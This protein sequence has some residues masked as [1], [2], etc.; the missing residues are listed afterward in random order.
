[1]LAAGCVST[2]VENVNVG[3]TTSTAPTA[4]GST[5]PA[6][7][8]AASGANGDAKTNAT[9]TEPDVLTSDETAPAGAS[10]Y[11][12]VAPKRFYDS[13][14]SLADCAGSVPAGTVAINAPGADVVGP[15][16]SALVVN[17]AVSEAAGPGQV[18]IWSA[19]GGAV[20]PEAPVV[21]LTG[22]C[23][24]AVKLT[25][26]PIPPGGSLHVATTVA[27][28]VALDVIG[29]LRPAPHGATAGRL[30]A[31]APTRILDSGASIGAT[32]P[33]PPDAQVELT[34]AGT[35]G[36]PLGVAGA[37]VLQLAATDGKPPGIVTAWAAG[38]DPPPNALLAIP[39]AGWVAS[40]LAIVP[41]SAQGKITVRTSAEANLVADI[42][43]FITSDSAPEVTTG[44]IIPSAPTRLLD[45]RASG[46][47]G[48]LE[49]GFRRDVS[50]T[51]APDGVG[52]VLVATDA[53]NPT[54]AG[55][56]TAYAAGTPRPG[57]VTVP[58]QGAG[59]DSVS[60]ALMRLGENGSV[61]LATEVSTDLAVDR[62]A[63][64][65][66]TPVPP[67]PTVPVVAPDT[68]GTPA[69]AAFDKVIQGF[70]SSRGLTGASVAI[71]K[72]G[73]IVYARAYG[74]MDDGGTPVRV[75]TRFRFASIS[76]V[77]TAAA[78]LQLI[79]AGAL[80]LNDSVFSLLSDR[81]PFN[82]NPDPRIVKVTVR[83]LLRHTSGF[84]KSTDPFF[85]E[86]PQ[87]RRVFGPSG[88]KTCLDAAKWFVTLPL[89]SDPGSQFAYVNMNYCLLSLLVEK[90]TNEAYDTV[91]Q[92][93]VLERRNVRDARIGA[94]FGRKPDE[95]SYPAAGGT[96]LESLSG[97][98]GWLGTSVDLARFIDGLDP[99]KPGQHLLK[100]ETYQQL[101]ESGQ[102]SWGLGVEIFPNGDWGHTGSLAG[103]RAMAVHQPDGITWGIVVNGT[104][105]NHN[106]VLRELMGRALA[107]VPQWPTIDYSPELP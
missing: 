1:M 57:T 92:S 63:W 102:G 97:A 82:D 5:R 69:N 107:T 45:T 29:V 60:P 23:D 101:I 4:V 22:T 73:R 79:Q 37:A 76:K 3:D 77:I 42:V 100:P 103:A 10:R 44:L 49:P 46:G 78:V 90:Y 59:L 94:S 104:F 80:S 34:V 41:M 13:G 36:V 83:D 40:N 50:I 8:V 62:L 87:V 86:Q 33:L 32:G 98:G 17:V 52:S 14:A 30:V 48:T 43:G 51:G 61:S 53:M 88:P 38:V 91:V 68:T 72:D 93:L 24:A 85:T 75:D 6:P 20:A 95:V 35:A 66:G 18:R 84:T 47:G 64:I 89:T 81:L 28:R 105:E 39:G 15:D 71:A 58:V 12:A 70:L 74:A 9:T 99:D 56:I 27:M 96:F 106:V 55:A 31:V 67:D 7:G 26:V 65:L 21:T 19:S 54:D 11:A 2:D 25:V 16:A